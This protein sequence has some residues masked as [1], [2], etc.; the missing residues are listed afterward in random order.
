MAPPPALIVPC[1]SVIPEGPII[2]TLPVLA[3]SDAPALLE[4]DSCE[5]R[6][7]RVRR[8]IETLCLVIFI[9]LKCAAEA[10][11]RFRCFVFLE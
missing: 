2:P 10:V 6:R 11:L 3:A 7:T 1:R 9:G 5:F 4:V 8:Q